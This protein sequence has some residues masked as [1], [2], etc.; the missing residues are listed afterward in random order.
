MTTSDDAEIQQFDDV[1]V[2]NTVWPHEKTINS[3]IGVD[4]LGGIVEPGDHIMAAGS[5]T[6]GEDDADVACFAVIFFCLLGDGV[7]EGEELKVDNL[8]LTAE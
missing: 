6:A 8:Y 3:G 4:P 7:A 5:R 1:A 2:D